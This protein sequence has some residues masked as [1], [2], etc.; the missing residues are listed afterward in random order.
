MSIIGLNL[1][2][3]SAEKKNKITGNLKINNNLRIINVEKE[4]QTFSSSDEVLNLSFKFDVAYD[5]EI[6]KLSMDG[7]LLYME[8]PNKAQ[9]IIEQ[10][11][12]EKKLPDDIS[13]TIF[14]A[15][16]SKCNIKALM[17]AHEVNLP[18]HFRLPYLKTNQN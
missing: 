8:E 7:S 12:K 3:I 4:K 13:S 14:N 5:P 18:P 11:E 9:K 17:I 2:N 10:W 1:N 15:I 6:G 16:L